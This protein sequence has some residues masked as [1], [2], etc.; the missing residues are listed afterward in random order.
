MSLVHR[1]PA[2]VVAAA[3]AAIALPAMAGLAQAAPIT[4][5]VTYSP[6]GLPAATGPVNTI[7]LTGDVG[8]TSFTVNSGANA[9]TIAAANGG[10]VV[11][12]SMLNAY[13]AP[14]TGGSVASPTT[15]TA[16]YLSTGG[17]PG[18]VTLSFAQQQ[19]Y[20][21]LLWGSIGSGDFINFLD[22]TGA[23][24]ASVTGTQAIQSASGFNASNGAQGFGGSQ[25]TLVNLNGG[26][27]S[28]I[29]LGQTGG[30]SFE[31]ANF[32]YAAQNVAVP[33]PA[34]LALLGLGL[35]GMGVIR[36]RKKA[37]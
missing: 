14:V 30:P 22:S 12:G 4:A 13:A 11:Q 1:A 19:S 31:S 29:V 36:R 7:A 34:S 32:E 35:A 27:F 18:T 33:E 21:G 2:R 28:S 25:Y 3:L 15:W 24:I 23:V 16:P 26:Q 8:Q 9:V 17:S 20:F 5:T 6:N 10:G 37:A